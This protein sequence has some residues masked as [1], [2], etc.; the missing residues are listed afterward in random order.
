MTS[1]EA[2]EKIALFDMDGT[3]FNLQDRMKEELE[4]MRGPTEPEIGDPFSDRSEYMENR[5]RAIKRVSGFW[6]T[7]PKYQPGWD[8]Y[9]IAKEMGYDIHILTKG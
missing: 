2:T 6:R 1:Q 4:K 7:L 5:R 9:E 8:V 3:L